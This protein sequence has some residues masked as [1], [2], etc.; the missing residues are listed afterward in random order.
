M[1][2]A[3]TPKDEMKN[4]T[5]LQEEVMS[6]PQEEPKSPNEDLPKNP[7]AVDCNIISAGD[8]GNKEANDG[9]EDKEED[10]QTSV[11]Q[12]WQ[13]IERQR[14]GHVGKK[15]PQSGAN[16]SGWRAVRLFVSST[17]QDFQNERE[18]LVKKVSA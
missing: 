9:S 17:F 13:E 18:V 16:L 8:G 2:G 12:C 15:Y 11:D 1:E 6:G 14:R 3:T 10:L 5:I 4:E 7:G